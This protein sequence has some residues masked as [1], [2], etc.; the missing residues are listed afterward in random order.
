MRAAAISAVKPIAFF[1]VICAFL[2]LVRIDVRNL[3]VK[4]IPER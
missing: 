3:S 4:D 2:W 1:I